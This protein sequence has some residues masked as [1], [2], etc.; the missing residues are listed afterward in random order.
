MMEVQKKPMRLPTINN[1]PSLSALRTNIRSPAAATLPRLSAPTPDT[2]GRTPSATEPTGATQADKCATPLARRAS[3]AILPWS[4]MY[5]VRL[6]RRLSRMQDHNPHRLL[7]QGSQG[8][9]VSHCMPKG[10]ASRIVFVWLTT[11][12]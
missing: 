7:E 1:I 4:V 9:C 5:A 2:G 11:G 6:W 8:P 10:N 12:S 3:P